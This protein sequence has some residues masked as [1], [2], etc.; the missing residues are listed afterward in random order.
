MPAVPEQRSPSLLSN[1]PLSP[2]PDSS[3]PGIQ[4]RPKTQ[5]KLTQA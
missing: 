3:N 1:D 2:I 5:A 4:P